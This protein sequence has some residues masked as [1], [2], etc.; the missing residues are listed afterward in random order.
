LI[1]PFQTWF[2]GIY[3][4]FQWQKSLQNQYLRHSE[5]K[6]YQINSIKPFSSSFFLTTP[7]AHS[8][9]SNFQVQFNLNFSEKIIQ[10]SRTFALQV[11]TSWNQA[12]EPLLIESFPKIPRIQYEASWFYGF[13]NYKTNYLPS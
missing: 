9:S 8:N 4:N 1:F 12:H 11:Q 6:S 7:K 5:S 3:L 10:Y 2:F 13:H